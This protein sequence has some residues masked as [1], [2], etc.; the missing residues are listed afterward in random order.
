MKKQKILIIVGPTASGK[1]ALGVSLAQHFGGEIISADS[2]QV[3]K[4]LDIGTGK[5]TKREMKGVPHHLLDISSP[6]KVVTAQKFTDKASAVIERM[7]KHGKLPFIVGGTGFYVDALTGRIPLPNVPPNTALRARLQKKTTQELFSLLKK[8]D[9]RRARMMNTPSERNNKVRLVRALE[10]ASA[11]KISRVPLGIR[12]YDVLWIG[13][14]PSE[15]E[16]EKNI[17]KRLSARLK[18][19]MIQEA[20]KLRKQGLS[21][22]RM[23]E[24]GL[25]YRSLAQFLKGNISRHELEDG[26]FRD[27]RRY[28]KKQRAYWKRNKEIQWFKPTETVRIKKEVARWLRK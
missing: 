24:L 11:P 18:G 22:K 12:R 8:R 14:A 13:I 15:K 21:L 5:I 20:Q 2:R 26:L 6:K 16:L 17:Q 23:E 4:G 27:I 1:S 10:I 28:A 9:P 7:G 19:G 3:Y 25:E